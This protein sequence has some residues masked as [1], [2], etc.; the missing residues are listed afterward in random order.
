MVRATN[1]YNLSTDSD[2]FDMN[3]ELYGIQKAPEEFE[4]P[5]DLIYAN[6]S[7]FEIYGCADEA[8]FRELTG[9]IWQKDFRPAME[10]L[11]GE[12]EAEPDGII[13]PL[14]EYI[15]GI[16]ASAA[17]NYKRWSVSTNTTQ[18]AAAGSFDNAV[19]FLRR[20]ITQRVEWMNGNYTTEKVTDEE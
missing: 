9:L 6:K 8:E 1:F 3:T 14:D 4:D 7:V 12:R 19:E 13:R 20:W 17:M 18:A 11:L 10:I 16:S 15:D 5:E 2:V